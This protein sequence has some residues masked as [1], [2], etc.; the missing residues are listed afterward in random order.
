MKLNRMMNR[1]GGAMACGVLLAGCT[2]QE[3]KQSADTAERGLNKI[4]N[5]ATKAVDK[6]TRVISDVSITGTIKAK[7][8]ATKALPAATIDVNTKN[9]VVTL[10]GSVQSASQRNLA[11]RLAKESPGANKVVNQ[12]VIKK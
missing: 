5:V 11:I 3:Q 8:L 12:L 10:N 4:G 6:T 1:I 9:N 7:I 2:Q